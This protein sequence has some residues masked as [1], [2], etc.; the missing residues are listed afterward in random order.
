MAILRAAFLGVLIRRS[1]KEKYL[2]I[3][4]FACNAGSERKGHEAMDMDDLLLRQIY[5]DH[6]DIFCWFKKV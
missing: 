2:Q 1:A 3:I 4:S 5:D 6:D